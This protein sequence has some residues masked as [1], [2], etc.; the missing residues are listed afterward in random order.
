MKSLRNKLHSRDNEITCC[1]CLDVF[2]MS[3][4]L[5]VARSCGH[6]FHIDCIN[7]WMKSHSTCPVCREYIVLTGGGLRTMSYHDLKKIINKTVGRPVSHLCS[8]PSIIRE[9]PHSGAVLTHDTM[10]DVLTENFESAEAQ[11]ADDASSAASTVD[12]DSVSVGLNSETEINENTDMQ[13]ANVPYD[14]QSTEET[15]RDDVA[16]DSDSSLTETAADIPSVENNEVSQADSQP[17][18]LLSPCLLRGNDIQKS[19]DDDI[20]LDLPSTSENSENNDINSSTLP[21]IP[22]IVPNVHIINHGGMARTLSDDSLGCPDNS[23]ARPQR[24]TNTNNSQTKVHIMVGNLVT[25]YNRNSFSDDIAPDY[26][27]TDTYS[28]SLSDNENN[29]SDCDGSTEKICKRNW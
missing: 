28:P 23:A 18:V 21:L 14:L 26:S 4:V 27:D 11:A 10:D 8:I 7:E 13:T 17:E 5:G 3:S 20:T 24:N 9:E 1:I 15:N 12:A 29:M 16:S 19:F 22:H 2:E 6:H 25:N